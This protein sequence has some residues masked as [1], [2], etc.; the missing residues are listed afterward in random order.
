MKKKIRHFCKIFPYSFIRRG[1]AG[2]YKDEMPQE[3]INK[4]D[5]AIKREMNDCPLYH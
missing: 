5:V 4:F 3:W 1:V 2:A